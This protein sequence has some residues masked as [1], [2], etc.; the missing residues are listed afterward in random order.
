MNLIALDKSQPEIAEALA[1]CE[2][3]VPKTITITVTP[4]VDSDTLFVASVESVEYSE[5]EATEEEVD[6]EEPV[7]KAYK[8]KSKSATAVEA[9]V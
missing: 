7:D 1:N 4:V 3:G 6:T 8:P 5:E 9:M 2:V